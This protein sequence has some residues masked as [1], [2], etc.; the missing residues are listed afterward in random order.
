MSRRERLRIY[1]ETNVTNPNTIRC[2][3]FQT[4]YAKLRLQLDEELGTYHGIDFDD[5]A[6]LH[7][8]ASK[9]AGT[10]GLEIIAADLGTS[11]S[12]ILRRLRPLEKIG[13]IAYY[14]DIKDRHVTLRTPGRSLIRTAHDTIDR[15]CVRPSLAG[16]LKKLN[17]AL[18]AS[19]T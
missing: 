18:L 16:L 1:R 5:F 14:G 11:R 8:L 12:A 15:V 13:L 7:S 4:A 9:G 10:A 17:E 2:L 6:L 19:G 3:S